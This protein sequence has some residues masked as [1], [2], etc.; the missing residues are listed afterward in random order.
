MCAHTQGQAQEHRE[1]DMTTSGSSWRG[2]FFLLLWDT[3]NLQV[4][5]IGTGEAVDLDEQL[6]LRGRSGK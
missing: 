5:P 2:A 3:Q 4:G 6:E 1:C